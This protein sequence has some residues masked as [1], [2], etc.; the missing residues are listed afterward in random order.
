MYTLIESAKLNVI[1][2]EAYL[3]AVIACIAQ[4]PIHKIHELLPWNITLS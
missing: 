2:P 1:D 3:R 4:Q